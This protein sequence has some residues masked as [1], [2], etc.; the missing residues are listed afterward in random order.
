M[1][2]P[3][4]LLDRDGTLIEEK[5]YLSD[6][7]QIVLLPGAAASL[8]SCS[9]MGLGLALVTNQS[10]I[11]RGYYTEARLQEIHTRLK[12]LL[13]E[14]SVYLDGIYYCP[15]T[16]MDNCTCRKPAEGLARQAERE[17]NIDLTRSFMVGDKPCDIGLGQRVG[18][19]T[20]L[21]RTGYGRQIEKTMEDHDVHPDYIVD[22]M[23]EMLTVIH[24]QSDGR[25]R[26]MK[27]S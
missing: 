15:H 20:F 16:S 22:D 3:F 11:G 12:A 4:I 13:K 18:A 8:R 6:P 14:Q 7:D 2:R 19:T 21:V 24:N 27:V 23:S 10:G 17:L 5:H 1:G 9:E 26:Q 25:D